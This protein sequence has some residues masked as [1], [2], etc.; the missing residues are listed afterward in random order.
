MPPPYTPLAPD[1]GI[2]PLPTRHWPLIQDEERT[3]GSVQFRHYLAYVKAAGGWPFFIA[4]FISLGIGQV[5]GVTKISC[6]GPVEFGKRGY[7]LTRDQLNSRS[8]GMFSRGTNR[9][10]EAR[11]YSHEGPIEFGKC[12]YVL[13]RDQSDA[14][15]ARP[16]QHH[17]VRVDH[18]GGQAPGA[19]LQVRLPSAVVLRLVRHLSLIHISEPTRPEPI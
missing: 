5:R 16:G 4:L 18:R 1:P 11:V 14:G 3:A 10:R 2:C 13:T 7:I 19:R 9:I 6:E 12:G 17:A 8:A 15:G